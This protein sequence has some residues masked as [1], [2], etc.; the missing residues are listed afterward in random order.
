M[1]TI[2]LYRQVYGYYTFVQAGVWVLYLCTG[3]CM[4]TIPLCRQ[5]DS[6]RR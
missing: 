6:G 2:A 3:R 5:V 4:G 1:G